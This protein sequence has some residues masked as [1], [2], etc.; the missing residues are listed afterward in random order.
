MTTDGLANTTVREKFMTGYGKILTEN[1]TG[2][3]NDFEPVSD[4]WQSDLPTSMSDEC[5]TFIQTSMS[6]VEGLG[7]RKSENTRSNYIELF[8]LQ[9]GHLIGNVKSA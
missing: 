9:P 2:A 4:M 6:F 8:S 1:W 7:E 5:R 3:S